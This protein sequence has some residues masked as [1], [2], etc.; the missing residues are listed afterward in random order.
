MKLKQIVPSLKENSGLPPDVDPR[1]G[2]SKRDPEANINMLLDDID[3]LVGAFQQALPS[4]LEGRDRWG[5]QGSLSE[6]KSKLLD[7]YQ[8]TAGKPYYE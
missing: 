3:E 5:T 2:L 7:L 4:M 1:T 6:I 8:F